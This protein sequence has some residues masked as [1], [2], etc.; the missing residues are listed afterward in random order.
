MADD[1]LATWELVSCCNHIRL[2]EHR[3]SLDSHPS[4]N[5]HVVFV[6]NHHHHP[7]YTYSR[8]Q[9]SPTVFQSCAFAFASAWLCFSQL[10]PSRNAYE[11]LTPSREVFPA[12]PRVSHS[13]VDQL[14]CFTV[15][16]TTLTFR[17]AWLTTTPADSYTHYHLRA[18]TQRARLANFTLCNFSITCAP[19]PIL[20]TWFWKAQ[21]VSCL[22]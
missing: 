9:L 6:D 16:L 7:I 22:Q 13:G 10:S 5:R 15:S 19:P 21:Q 4:L 12:V 3:K 1:L 11:A 14:E 2:F 8:L 18:A 17:A 20:S